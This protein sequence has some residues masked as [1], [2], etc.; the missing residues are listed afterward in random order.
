MSERTAI[1]VVVLSRQ[2]WQF[3]EDEIREAHID[4]VEFTVLPEIG[5]V[6]QSGRA[7]DVAILC[8]HLEGEEAAL[9]EMRQ[10]GLAALYGVWFW[11][12]HHHMRI[13]LRIA[14]LA[15]LIFV[16]HWHERQHLNFSVALAA[17]H[18]PAHSRQWSPGAIDRHY[19]TG[20]PADQRDSLFGGFGRYIWATER[21]RFIEA[22][23][24]ACPDHSLT[25]GSVNDYFHRSA[26]DRLGIWVAHKVQL[27]VPINRD[28]ST[29]IFEALITGQIPLVPDDLP[30]FDHIIDPEHQA[31][32]SILRY[33]AGDIESAKAAWQQAL[34]QFDSLGAEGVRRRH[35]FARTRHA[36]VS[37]LADFVKFL[38]HPGEFKL[39]GDN[40]IQYWARWRAGT[41][42]KSTRPQDHS[43]A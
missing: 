17:S 27:I 35:E 12:N 21:N 24:S 42:S 2:K 19:P 43:D 8:C 29:R 1:K 40:Q 13:N 25:L 39:F 14:M 4:G 11:E 36:L 32:L 33:R 20:L 6:L 38:R 37:R 5:E 28:V 15:D 22:V 26:A 34:V 9:F 31:T 10:H 18:I 30:D 7:F 41:A 23:M 3:C 16:S